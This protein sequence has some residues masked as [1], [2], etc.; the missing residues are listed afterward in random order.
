VIAAISVDRL[1]NPA[2][3]ASVG[4]DPKTARRVAR[5]NHHHRASAAWLARKA[6]ETFTTAG[7]IQGPA[8]LIWRWAGLLA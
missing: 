1:I 3:Y 8:K 7:L 2:A 5:R 4:L 6:V